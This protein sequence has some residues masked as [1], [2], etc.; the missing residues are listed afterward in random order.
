MA[1]GTKP[2][3]SPCVLDNLCSAD[4]NCNQ[5]S[6]SRIREKNSSV[7]SSGVQ[8]ANVSLFAELREENTSMLVRGALSV[9]SKDL[10]D[11][12]WWLERG[13]VMEINLFFVL[14]SSE[15]SNVGVD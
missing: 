3:K 13:H 10:E 5:W 11:K 2:S 9:E 8:N 15:K 6:S 12:T 4:V 14:K 1:E 7:K